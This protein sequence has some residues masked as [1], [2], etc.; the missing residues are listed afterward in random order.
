MKTR[1]KFIYDDGS[2]GK[3]RHNSDI[4]ISKETFK[5]DGQHIYLFLNLKDMYF[6]FLDTDG[7]PIYRGG[8]TTNSE[9]LLKQAKDELKKRG[10][11]FA[12]ETRTKVEDE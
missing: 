1:I 8:N 10:C 2:K 4:A 7:K 3:N 6:E 12:T 5:V 11:R 9:I